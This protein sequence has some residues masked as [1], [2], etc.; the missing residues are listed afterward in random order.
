[1]NK[2][3]LVSEI[4]KLAKNLTAAT[5]IPDRVK[6]AEAMIKSG[7]RGT[8]L[9]IR[10]IEFLAH[11]MLELAKHLRRIQGSLG[12]WEEGEMAA[13]LLIAIEQYK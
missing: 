13:E 6:N 3:A 5:S 1:M 7:G 2:V 4:L 12:N 11:D 8:E 9:G 10:E